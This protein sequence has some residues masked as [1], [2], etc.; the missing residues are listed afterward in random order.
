MLTGIFFR[1]VLH[2]AANGTKYEFMMFTELTFNCQR[3]F[4]LCTLKPPM[5]A[6]R[7]K[8]LRVSITVYH[9]IYDCCT[10]LTGYTAEYTGQFQVGILEYTYQPVV[11]GR[12]VL[13]ELAAIARQ[14]TQV[15]LVL[16]RNETTFQQT[17]T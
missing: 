7:G 5:R 8:I 15:T 13:D 1:Q 14:V 6:Q 4:F 9:I 10:S 16:I 3:Y 2:T 12:K 17:C 11:F